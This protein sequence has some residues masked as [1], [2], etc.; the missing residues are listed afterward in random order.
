MKYTSSSFRTFCVVRVCM[1]DNCIDEKV[2]STYL[3]VL[4]TPRWKRK[5]TFTILVVTFWNTDSN[6]LKLLQ[7]YQVCVRFERWNNKL[8]IRKHDLSMLLR[9]TTLT[10]SKK[11]KKKYF[12]LAI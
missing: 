9:N 8:Q 3:S 10:K 4:G 6:K 7:K 12:M 1:D 11:K 5:A 2:D